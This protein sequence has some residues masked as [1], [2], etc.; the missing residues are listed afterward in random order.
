MSAE[1]LAEALQQ[2][3]AAL[4][5]VQLRD[6]DEELS[7]AERLWFTCISCFLVVFAGLMAGLTLGL[8][9]LDK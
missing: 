8:L 1:A 5:S 9:S 7:A 3:Q 2:C 6:D 4:A